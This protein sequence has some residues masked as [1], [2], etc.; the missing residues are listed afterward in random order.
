M[1]LK[2]L[3]TVKEIINNVTGQPLASEKIFGNN[4]L[5][6]EFQT[7]IYKLLISQ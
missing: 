7:K 5:N 1:I 4:T 3:F 2:Q 6:E